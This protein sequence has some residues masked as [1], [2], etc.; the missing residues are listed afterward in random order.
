M[1]LRLFLG[2]TFVYA[3]LQKVSD[4]GF[5]SAG[6]PTYIGSQLAV[7]ARTSPI[8]FLIHWFALPLAQLTGVM[9]IATEL[10]I[11]IMVLAGVLT[12]PAALAGGAVNLTF[13][14]T[15]TWSVQ[16]YFLGSDSIYAVAWITLALTGD[17]GVLTMQPALERW[18]RR[19]R[20]A[21]WPAPADLNRRQFLMILGAAGT[22]IVWVLAV[23]PRAQLRV[24]K[25]SVSPARPTASPSASAAAGPVPSPSPSSGLRGGTPIG[26][27]SQMRASSG[28]LDFQNPRTGDPGVA[29]ELPGNQLVAFDAI[30]TH[31]GCTVQYDPQYK[32]LVCPC[33]GAAFDP[34]RGAAV[35]QGPA[36]SPLTRLTVRL[37]P[38]GTV[39]L[40]A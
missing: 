31:A 1:P 5:L 39:Y 33:H 23:L 19:D 12:R 32:L 17:G 14:L 3:G 20:P 22:A 37:S 9:V 25:A 16:P 13:F 35:V 10:A 21:R 38:D 27:L 36:P 30:C 18:F 4:S 11:G 26:S 8:A 15:A 40:E 34:A 24:Q 7:Y 29:V 6:S 28:S 2:V